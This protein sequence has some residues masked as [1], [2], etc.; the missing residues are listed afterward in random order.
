M[1][2]KNESPGAIVG[3]MDPVG[4]VIRTV[5][6]LIVRRKMIPTSTIVSAHP[7]QYSVR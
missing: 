6:K 5:T 1:S 7:S 3:F 2:T 4:T